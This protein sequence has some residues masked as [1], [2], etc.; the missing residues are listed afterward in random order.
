MT[1]ANF[2]SL[3]LWSTDQNVEINQ[4]HHLIGGKS[5]VLPP[6]NLHGIAQGPN[7]RETI[8][9]PP[10]A[11]FVV[12]LVPATASFAAGDAFLPHP[13]HPRRHEVISVTPGER[14]VVGQAPAGQERVPD[15]IHLLFVSLNFECQAHKQCGWREGGLLF[16]CLPLAI[17]PP[18]R[19]RLGGGRFNFGTYATYF[20]YILHTSENISF[21]EESPP[22]YHISYDSIIISCL[23]RIRFFTLH[24]LFAQIFKGL[25]PPHPLRCQARG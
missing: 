4:P 1:S 21:V 9:T 10:R 2:T 20:R 8:A 23:F 25:K 5:T 18:V 15:E 7:Q 3:H 24:L 6:P 16:R 14:A 22:K 19:A 17:R 11:F 13:L 12:P